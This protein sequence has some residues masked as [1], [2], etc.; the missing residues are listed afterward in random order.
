MFLFLLVVVK[1]K[2]FIPVFKRIFILLEVAFI[3]LNQSSLNIEI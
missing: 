2:H 1:N 3:V